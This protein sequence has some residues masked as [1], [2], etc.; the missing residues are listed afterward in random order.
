[1]MP[2][3]MQ[4]AYQD[5]AKA[6]GVSVGEWLDMYAYAYPNGKTETGGTSNEK[7]R[8]AA[9]EYIEKQSWGEVK[10]T[11]AASAVY[12][13]LTDTVPLERDVPYTWALGQGDSGLALVE[14]S[15]S[16]TQKEN[17]EKYVKGHLDNDKMKLYLDAYAYKGTAKSDKD[18]DG[19]T[20]VSAKS[21]VI[22]YI[23]SLDLT[24]HEKIRIF[25]GLDYAESGI[26]Y[27]W[28]Y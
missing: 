23:D 24:N 13:Y 2:E 8:E 21:K 1:M 27:W 14:N 28:M 22:E 7:I 11:A 19:N 3:K 6:G 25:L 5:V 20:V 10:K 26:P 12:Q 15:M 4:T 18:A 17:Y 9:L 16:K